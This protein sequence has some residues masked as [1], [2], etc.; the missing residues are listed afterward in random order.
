MISILH[1]P[2]LTQQVQFGEQYNSPDILKE[3]ESLSTKAMQ[4]NKKNYKAVVERQ[5]DVAY[6]K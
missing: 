3:N 1:V 4:P 5:T 6:R 2:P